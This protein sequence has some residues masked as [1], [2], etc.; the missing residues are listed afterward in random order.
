MD[1][2][3]PAEAVQLLI[4]RG[5]S[6]ARIG[7]EVG[8]SQPTIHRIK[9]GANVRFDTGLAVIRIAAAEAAND[10]VGPREEDSNGL[11]DATVHV[12]C[13]QGAESK[14]H[15]CASSDAC[16]DAATMNGHPVQGGAR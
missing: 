14:V 12:K 15:G 1:I 7:K 3:T 13:A 2:M 10:D 5:W 4:A 11:A 9:N 16:P 8:T 6:E